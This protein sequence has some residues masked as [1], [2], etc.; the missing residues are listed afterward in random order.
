MVAAGLDYWE[1]ETPGPFTGVP[2]A[3]RLEAVKLAIEL[4][5]D[6]NAARRLRRLPRWTAT[7]AT[8]CS[9]TRTT[10]TSCSTSASAIRAG[11]A[12]RRCIGAIMS[13]QPSIVQY[14]VDHGADVNAKTKLGWTPL[15]VAEG[16]FCCNA[17]KEFPAAAAIIRKAHGGPMNRSCAVVAIAGARRSRRRGRNSPQT[18]TYVDADKVAAAFAKGGALGNRSR[19]TPPRSPA[20][21]GPARSK[22]TTRKPT[23]STSSTATATFVTG[24]TM[25]GGKELRAEPVARHRHPGRPDASTEEGRLHR[26]S[27][28]HAALVQGR[29]VERR[30]T[31]TWS[32]W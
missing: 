21:P 24:G 4:G 32:R 12:A 19:L 18:V 23:S 10:S 6:V 5:N 29:A 16:V 7:S 20:A 22:C 25:V 30:S 27:G 14:L 13:D 2:E 1:G 9:T 26:H 15:H 28:G 8:R 11:A 31:T 17:K 3:E